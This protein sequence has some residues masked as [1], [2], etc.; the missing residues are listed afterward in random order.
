[1]ID[2]LT[3]ETAR[4]LAE[5]RSQQRTARAHDRH[6]LALAAAF[7]VLLALGWLVTA[8]VVAL[9]AAVLLHRANARYRR[10]L[11]HLHLAA[12]LQ[13]RVPQ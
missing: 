12:W 3:A 9:W 5:A 11:A 10:A 1:M 2:F 13:G 6:A 7:G 8:T 4:I